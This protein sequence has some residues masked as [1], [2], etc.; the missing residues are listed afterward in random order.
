[1]ITAT[2]IFISAF[3]L[4]VLCVAQAPPNTP[5]SS[6]A[7]DCCVTAIEHVT[8]GGVVY[9]HQVC[10]DKSPI[11]CTVGCG[12]NG[13]CSDSTARCSCITPSPTMLPTMSL[14]STVQPTNMYTPTPTSTSTSIPSAHPST[15]PTATPSLTQSMSPTFT[16]S[17]SSSLVFPNATSQ[18]HRHHSS[19]N[20]GLIGGLFG[21]FAAL[22]LFNACFMI[23]CAFLTLRHRHSIAKRYRERRPTDEIPLREEEEHQP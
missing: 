23:I 2:G 14:T 11:T 15:E 17:P 7:R 12:C 16:V 10:T 8:I 5:C 9:L 20:G 13:L 3:C 22:V 6:A 19:S 1:M 21:G 4:I 18:H